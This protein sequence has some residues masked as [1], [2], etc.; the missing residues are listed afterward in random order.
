MSPGFSDGDGVETA[1]A[2]W[3][4]RHVASAAKKAAEQMSQV[5]ASRLDEIELKLDG[6]RASRPQHFEHKQLFN[7]EQSV[8]RM[9]AIMKKYHA[10]APR[11]LSR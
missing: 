6:T 7:I 8:A 3:K 1:T 4:R 5:L 9:A 10:T 2:S 11:E